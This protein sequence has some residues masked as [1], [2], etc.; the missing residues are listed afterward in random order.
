[1]STNYYHVKPASDPCACCKRFDPEVVTHV[2][3]SSTGWTFA[4]HVTDD[5][6]SLDDW[7]AKFKEHGSLIR[8]E[9]NR[10]VPVEEMLSIITERGFRREQPFDYN[11]NFAEP[12]PC[13]LARRKVDGKYCIGQGEGTWDLCAG[14]FS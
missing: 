14:D 7:K 8:D 1:M 5:L 11:S 6:K 2:G 9:Y 10:V 3:L 13:G 4:L 12:G